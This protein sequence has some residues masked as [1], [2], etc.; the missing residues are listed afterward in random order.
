MDR[1]SEVH[2]TWHMQNPMGKAYIL[3]EMSAKQW[4]RWSGSSVARADQARD[5]PAA[6]PL[7]P[8]SSSVM[9]D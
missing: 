3:V 4:F 1:Y 6:T 8:A 2:I 9:N 7:A 5:E